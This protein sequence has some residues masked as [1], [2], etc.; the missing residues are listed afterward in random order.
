M[1]RGQSHGERHLTRN[2]NLRCEAERPVLVHI[3]DL[4]G[5]TTRRYGAQPPL[6]TLYV[7][8]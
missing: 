6:A 2:R 8:R 7:S 1:H 3:Q 4:L 5:H